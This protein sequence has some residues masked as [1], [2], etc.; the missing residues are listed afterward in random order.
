MSLLRELEKVTLKGYFVSIFLSLI[1]YLLKI[2]I[3]LSVI[4]EQKF[5]DNIVKN[6]NENKNEYLT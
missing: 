1:H 4:N 6:M 5:D 3:F 2:P